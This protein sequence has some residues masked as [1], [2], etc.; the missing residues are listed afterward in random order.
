MSAPLVD[1]EQ[2]RN[3]ARKARA[4]C[5]LVDQPPALARDKAL[6]LLSQALADLL[7]LAL[8]LPDLSDEATPEVNANCEPAASTLQ[9]WVSLLCLDHYWVVFD[10]FANP[11]SSLT[12]NSLAD[13]LSDV[14]SDLKRGLFLFEAG[15]VHA[16][17]WEWRSS[18][19][20]HWGESLL[21]AQRALFL[22]SRR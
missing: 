22:A 17:C 16:A 10:P 14:Y 15:L 13:D 21:E 8:R 3:F 11:E 7:Q 12:F 9:E 5:A 1:T 6:L 4:Y 2:A 19:S 20:S 18:F